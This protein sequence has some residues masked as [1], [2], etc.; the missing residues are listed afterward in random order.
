MIQL[1]NKTTKTIMWVADNRADEYI[2]AGH[3]P[4]AIPDEKPTI[5]EPKPRKGRKKEV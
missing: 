3:S 1:I 4:V 2:A 5:E